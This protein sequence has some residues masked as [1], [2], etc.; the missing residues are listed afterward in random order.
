MEVIATPVGPDLVQ[1]IGA[2]I[3]M[4]GSGFCGTTVQR[5]ASE[6]SKRMFITSDTSESSN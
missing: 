3:L 2:A 6:D 5:S 1:A 4:M